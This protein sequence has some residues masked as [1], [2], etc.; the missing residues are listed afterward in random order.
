MKGNMDQRRVPILLYLMK[1]KDLEFERVLEISSY[2]CLLIFK[3][4]KEALR[5]TLYYPDNSLTTD[6]VLAWIE[7]EKRFDEERKIT[8]LQQEKKEDRCCALVVVSVL[9]LFWFLIPGI[10]AWLTPLSVAPSQSEESK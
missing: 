9:V 6:Q 3:R 10:S 7:D 8:K 4:D 5:E 1:H 2:G